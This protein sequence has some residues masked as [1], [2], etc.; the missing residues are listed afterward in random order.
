MNLKSL[1]TK[2][3]DK[4][5]LQMNMV[6][7]DG[8]NGGL[9]VNV[10]R[11]TDIQAMHETADRMRRVLDRQ[12]AIYE[13]PTF[14]EKLDI[15]EAQLETAKKD[16]VKYQAQADEEEAQQNAPRTATVNTLDN[17]KTNVEH[18]TAEVEIGRGR[19]ENIRKRTLIT[20][21]S[22]DDIRVLNELGVAA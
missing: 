14:Q 22:I 6:V 1:F 8:F 19:V 12:R 13:L 10:P 20:E 5:L 9:S 4:Y 17:L 21:Q 2:P 3:E 7:G 15:M 11:S 18:L 16:M